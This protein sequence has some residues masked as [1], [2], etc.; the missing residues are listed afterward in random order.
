MSQPI[1]NDLTLSNI[2]TEVIPTETSPNNSTNN[3]ST[4][5]PSPNDSSKKETPTEY[6]SSKDSSRQYFT[7]FCKDEKSCKKMGYN[8]LFGFLSIVL[9]LLLIL[10][11]DKLSSFSEGIFKLLKIFI[12]YTLIIATIALFIKAL[13]YLYWW[14]NLFYWVVARLINPLISKKVNSWYYY[15]T[16][17]VNWIVY[18]FAEIIYFICMVGLLL[19]LVLI[20]LPAVSF[21]GF[22]IGFLFSMMGDDR[23]GKF[24]I[25]TKG[26]EQTPD[27][28]T[29]TGR[30]L[31]MVKGVIPDS[32]A[33]FATTAMGNPVTSK[34]IP[35]T[36][37]MKSVMPRAKAIV[38][39]NPVTGIIKD[40]MPVVAKS[41]PVVTGIMKGAIPVVK[42]MPVMGAMNPLIKGSV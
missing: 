12:L 18:G 19:L 1:S 3:S 36:G 31:N 4:K 40:A 9:I 13:S 25:S 26:V 33:K 22:L 8:I 2:P 10:N 20:I 14:V 23:C 21:I 29:G 35:V 5:D 42:G 27:T 17:Y 34:E 39:G 15:F 28:G 6:S 11:W 16:D 30:L 37:I 41:I 32:I 7:G 38:T 24:S